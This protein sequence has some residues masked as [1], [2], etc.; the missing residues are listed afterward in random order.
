MMGTFFLTSMFEKTSQ[1]IPF[2]FKKIIKRT[3][4]T[5]VVKV[6]PSFLAVKRFVK[7]YKPELCFM[8]AE[9]KQ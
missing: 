8:Y 6:I 2:P 1:T 4:K 5:F 3:P 9:E 7:L